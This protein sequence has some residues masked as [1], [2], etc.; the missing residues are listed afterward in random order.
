[1]SAVRIEVAAPRERV[2]AVLSEPRRYADWVVGTRVVRHADE[3]FPERGSRF[4]ASVGGG[5]AELDAVTTVLERDEPRRLVLRTRIRRIGAAQIDLEL[6]EVGASTVVTMRERTIGDPLSR[7][8]ARL[9]EPVLAA[10]NRRSLRK[11]KDLVE[12][13]A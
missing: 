13:G 6:E 9:G 1:M 12:R 3:S 8:A 11:L 7:F 5:P 4:T 2:F 10:R